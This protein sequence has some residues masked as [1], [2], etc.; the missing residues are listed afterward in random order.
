[1]NSLYRPCVLA[2]ISNSEGL[3]LVG[4]R[5]EPPGSWQFPQG[6]IDEGETAEVAVKREVQEEIGVSEFFVLGR[7]AGPIRYDFPPEVSGPLA[8]KYKGQDQVWFHLR[9]A[10]GHEPSLA[11]ASDR[12]FSKL[13]WVTVHEALN[14]VV[15]FKREAYKEGLQALGLISAS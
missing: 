11:K 14:R 13:T 7:S 9:L 12:E 3:V 15:S 1:M 2:V 4:E 8:K 5:I 10:P 6:G